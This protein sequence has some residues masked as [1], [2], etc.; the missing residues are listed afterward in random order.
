MTCCENK[1]RKKLLQFFAYLALAGG[2]V[3]LATILCGC[4]MSLSCEAAL[5]TTD[6]E[7]QDERPVVSYP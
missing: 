7:K 5:N 1:F 4:S 3:Y 2:I 6:S